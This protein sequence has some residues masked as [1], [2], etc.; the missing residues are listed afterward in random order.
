[1]LLLALLLLVTWRGS[2]SGERG[3]KGAVRWRIITAYLL[4]AWCDQKGYRCQWGHLLILLI[5]RWHTRGEGM[6]Y[7][8]TPPGL[9]T[10]CSID[11]FDWVVRTPWELYNERPRRL[12]LS[13]DYRRTNR[14]VVFPKKNLT[15]RI[16]ILVSRRL[17]ALSLT[18]PNLNV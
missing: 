14:K 18:R 9:L 7:V 10:H 12:M 17:L 13:L 3:R 16:Y 1:M 4:P 5:L 11:N 8:I 6:S 15:V 2:V